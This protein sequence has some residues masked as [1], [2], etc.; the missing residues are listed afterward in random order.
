M[1]FNR[2]VRGFVSIC[3]GFKRHHRRTHTNTN[4]SSNKSLKT[5]ACCKSEH[6]MVPVNLLKPICIATK[7]KHRS[8][9]N[10]TKVLKTHVYNSNFTENIPTEQQQPAENFPFAAPAS[11]S[12]SHAHAQLRLARTNESKSKSKSISRLRGVG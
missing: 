3:M 12:I 2:L 7:D 8:K 1:G 10:H 5:H 4:E 9:E 6:T 11:G